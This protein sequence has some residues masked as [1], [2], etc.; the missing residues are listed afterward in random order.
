MERTLKKLEQLV[1]EYYE[2]PHITGN[3]TENIVNVTN[4]DLGDKMRILLTVGN[5]SPKLFR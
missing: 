5:A 4:Y 3:S 2:Y 1:S